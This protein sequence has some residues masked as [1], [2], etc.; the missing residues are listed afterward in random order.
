ME[1]GGIKDHTEAEYQEATAIARQLG[2]LPLAV[3]QGGAFVKSRGKLL[4][5]FRRIFGQRQTELLIFK[6][7]LAEN[8]EIGSTT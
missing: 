8:K 3:D 1:K 2:C 5:D 6:L 4:A 7:R